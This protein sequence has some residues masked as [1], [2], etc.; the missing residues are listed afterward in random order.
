M[1][2]QIF[3][4][5]SWKDLVVPPDGQ[6]DIVILETKYL[7]GDVPVWLSA[8]QKRFAIWRREFLKPVQGMGFLFEGPLKHH[9][10][11]NLFRSMIAAYMTNS[12]LG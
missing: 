5:D 11:A 12:R 4:D 6:S 8:L 9:D 1:S 10:E 3:G 7:Q 2:S